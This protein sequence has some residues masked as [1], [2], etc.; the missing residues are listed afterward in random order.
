MSEAAANS[1]RNILL[2]VDDSSSSDNLLDYVVRNLYRQGDVVH[3]LHVIAPSRTLVVTPDMGLD[4]VIEDDEETKR[5]VEQ[6]AEEFIRERFEKRL[7]T[8]RIPYQVDI[9]RG[10]VDKDSIGALVCQR[11]EQVEAVA[12]VM[13]KHSRG[14]IKEFFIGSVTNYACHHCKQPVLV[15]HCD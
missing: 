2:T 5:K 14:P 10:C 15:L 11:A 13:A 6:H 12:V 4:G 9:V 3:V 7:E 1:H 8:M